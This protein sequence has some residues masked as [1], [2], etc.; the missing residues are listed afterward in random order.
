MKNKPSIFRLLDKTGILEPHTEK[1]FEIICN[2]DELQ[3]FVD[4]LIF[5]VKEGTD[6][7]VILKC[8]GK[9]NTA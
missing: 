5:S 4:I 6:S 3:R 8:R 9:G 7:E 2:P 1:I